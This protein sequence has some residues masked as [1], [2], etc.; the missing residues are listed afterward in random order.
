MDDPQTTPPAPTPTPTPP[1]PQGGAG[2]AGGA[3]GSSAAQEEA[4]ARAKERAKERARAVARAV[5]RRRGWKGWLILALL[6]G[7]AGGGWWWW[8]YKY[9]AQE[10][11]LA[12]ETVAVGRGEVTLTVSATGTLQP[13]ATV[14]L[15][16]EI[17]GRVRAV[18]AEDNA[19]VERDFELAHLDTVDLENAAQQAEI[20]LRS[21][22]A[23]TQIAR[24]TLDEVRVREA[25]VTKLVNGGGAPPGDL[26]AVKAERRRAAAQV[27]KA[28]AQE[29]LAAV[30]LSL[31]QAN[32]Q[33][34]VIKSPI[35]G[36]VL[37]RNV[38]PGN[39]IAASLQSP[40]LFLLAED[41]TQMRLEVAVDEAD[42]GLVRAGQP[43]TFTV[44]AW[45]DRTFEASV[46]SVNLAANATESV[47]TYTAILH[48][49]NAEGL[50]RPGMTAT[51]TVIAERRTDVLR[52]PAAALRFTPRKPDE[53]KTSLTLVQAPRRPGGGNQRNRNANSNAVWV[54]RDGQTEPA[55]VTLK[56]GRS[57]GRFT[58]V[59]E[60]L[61]A[62]DRVVIGQYDP[63]D[64]DA[65]RR[66]QRP[67]NGDKP[68][69]DKPSGDKPKPDAA[70]PDAPKPDAP[71]PDAPSND[72]K[73][74][75]ERRRPGGSKP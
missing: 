69:G 61:Q 10:Q 9:S 2:G 31:A 43:A 74:P 40:E 30:R 22:K 60:G 38:E 64:P 1:T 7:G 27:T 62:G 68:S 51:A 4:N 55:R 54:L 41:L 39:T 26:E 6:L 70:K 48:V 14:S 17:S 20:T 13:Q 50:L 56:L 44:D 52:V 15:G 24:A 37:K 18:H 45:P 16:S 25:R 28:Q 67:T 42:V 53:G 3:G 46:A 5:R 36:V 34:A 58:E 29:E 21:A 35:R 11:T 49:D 59:V 23:D 65:Q 33:K 32:I 71:K 8:T 12:W 57:D 73:A 63:N 75:S 19:L 72:D 47:V 66:A